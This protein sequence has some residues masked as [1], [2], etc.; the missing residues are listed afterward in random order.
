MKKYFRKS[1]LCLS[2]AAMSL[3]TVSCEEG[4]IL[5]EGTISI[6]SQ[7][8]NSIFQQGQTNQYAGAAQC[9]YLFGTYSDETGFQ[10]Q[11]QT[12]IQEV[13]CTVQASSSN[14]MI[15]LQIPSITVT[16]EG[17]QATISDLAIYNLA[18]DANGNL[19]IGE[20][21]TIDGSITAPDGN[22]YKLVYP[23]ISQAKINGQTLTFVSSLYFGEDYAR[24][25]NINFTGNIVTAAL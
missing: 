22:S 24:V 10:A 21:T 20:N 6:L 5:N 8:L 11:G 19:T 14:N 4:G 25:M 3:T 17:Q 12:E 16:R 15:T 18:M 9:Q 2:I 1:M 7:L 13:K 23:Y